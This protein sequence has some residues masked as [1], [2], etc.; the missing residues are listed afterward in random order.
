MNT[1]RFVSVL[2]ANMLAAGLS[3]AQSASAPAAAAAIKVGL[4]ETTTATE[5][6][7][8][9]SKHSVVGRTCVT[10]AEATNLARIVP[11]QREF[12]MRCENSD[13]KREGANIAWVISCKSSSATQNGKGRMSFFGDSYL[14]TA[15]VEL[16]KQGS[17]P[18]KLSQSF[19]GKWVQACS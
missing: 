11:P 10:A 1:S 4:W 15:E 12:G 5:D 13:L 19:S 16:R 2:L 9:N 8:T 18:V 6:S 7:S 17:K 3:C 14:G